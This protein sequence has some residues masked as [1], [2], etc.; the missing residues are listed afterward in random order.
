MYLSKYIKVYDVDLPSDFLQ[1]LIDAYEVNMVPAAVGNGRIDPKSR[2]CFAHEITLPEMQECV[3][4]VVDD[5]IYKYAQ[6][7][8]QAQVSKNDGGYTFLKYLPGCYYK[9]HVDSGSNYFR[10]LSIII[11][12]NDAYE[13][14]DISFFDGQYK[15]TVTANQAVVFPSNFLFPHQVETITSGARY[16][17]ATWVY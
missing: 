14:G 4:K 8:P 5:V 15:L 6:E 1:T 17:I 2:K 9:Q 16:T 12:L 7:F 10:T 13:G 3:Y 11:V